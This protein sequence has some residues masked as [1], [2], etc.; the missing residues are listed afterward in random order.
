MAKDNGKKA[1]EEA[2]EVVKLLRDL[3]EGQKNLGLTNIQI[4]NEIKEHGSRL[5][6]I[7]NKLDLLVQRFDHFVPKSGEQRKKDLEKISKIETR[8]KKVETDMKV[9]KK[10]VG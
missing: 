5:N 8:L 4:L 9:L 3:V 10:K 2:S 6:K 7:D 1:R